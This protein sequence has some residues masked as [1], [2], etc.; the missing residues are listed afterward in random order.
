MTNAPEDRKRE[1][2]YNRLREVLKPDLA[3]AVIIGMDKKCTDLRDK[4]IR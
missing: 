1:R 4:F 3:T 2:L